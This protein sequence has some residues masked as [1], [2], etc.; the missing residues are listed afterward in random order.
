L[1]AASLHTDASK[2]GEA[3][4]SF[5]EKGA[6]LQDRKRTAGPRRE[7]FDVFSIIRGGHGTIGEGK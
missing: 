6:F 7:E 5:Y 1:I 2:R 3:L 4:V